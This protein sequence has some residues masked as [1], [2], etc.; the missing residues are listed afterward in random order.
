MGVADFK[1][2]VVS[3]AAGS[4]YAENMGTK[5]MVAV[6]GPRPMN[7]SEFSAT[8]QLKCDFKVLV[9]LGLLIVLE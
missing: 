3:R 2:G 1:T 6:Y 8:G 5:V 9:V 7:T 4:V